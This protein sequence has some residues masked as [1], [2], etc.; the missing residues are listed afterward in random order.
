MKASKKEPKYLVRGLLK[1][2]PSYLPDFVDFRQIIFFPLCL[3]YPFSLNRTHNAKMP[4]ARPVPRQQGI[5]AVMLNYLPAL[6]S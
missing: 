3:K 6:P 2:L 1:R 5:F 4:C